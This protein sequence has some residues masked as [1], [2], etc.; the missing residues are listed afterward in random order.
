MDGQIYFDLTNA[1]N[2][3]N[4]YWADTAPTSTVFSLGAYSSNYNVNG[5]QY[6]AYC[7]KS[8]SGFSKIGSYTGTGTGT[9]V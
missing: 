2:A 5:N 8:T 3:S 6:I 4:L 9:K 7:F 1:D